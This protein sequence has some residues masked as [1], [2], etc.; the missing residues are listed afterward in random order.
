MITL[1]YLSIHPSS[2][3]FL[4][5]IYLS[6]Y[7]S[8]CN[9][10]QTTDVVILLVCV[11]YKNVAYLFVPWIF[12]C[13]LSVIG[14]CWSLLWSEDN[15][16]WSLFLK[17]CW[18]LFCSLGCNL[19]WQIFYGHWKKLYSAL[20]RS[21]VVYKCQLDSVRGIFWIL[22]CL[23]DF[24]SSSINCWK[25]SV[26]V[27]NL[28]TYIC[29]YVCVYTHVL[30]FCFRPHLQHMEV[31][32]P[33]VKSELQLWSLP[34]PPQQQIWAASVIYAAAC[35]NARSLTHWARPRIEPAS[36]KRQCWATMRTTPV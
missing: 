22:L 34:Q 24:L 35:G 29:M 5:S 28:H 2:I 19:F 31:S 21:N 14:F 16:V 11:K 32:G 12:F 27:F 9:L 17:N 13:Y 6:I 30:L 7:L 10:S 15:S 1:W 18:D 26:E 4:S 25:G 3:I 23:D 8:I 33:G 36:S 20:A